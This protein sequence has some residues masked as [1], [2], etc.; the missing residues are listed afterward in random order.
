MNI[1]KYLILVGMANLI[2]LTIFDT[3]K[4]ESKLNLK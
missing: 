1:K 4:N 3:A 2:F